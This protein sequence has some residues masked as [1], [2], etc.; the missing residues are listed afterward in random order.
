MAGETGKTP[1]LQGAG[2]FVAAWFIHIVICG[3]M[4]WLASLLLGRDRD[5][6]V[7]LNILAGLGGAWV[8]GLV[9][10]GGLISREPGLLTLFAAFVGALL[11]VWIVNYVQ[12]R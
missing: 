7:A 11:V 6:P 3:M 8:S 12:R 1:H 9:F 10:G 5:M 2:F 4:G